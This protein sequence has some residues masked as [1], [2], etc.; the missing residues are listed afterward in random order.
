MC[1]GP[2][3]RC[4]LQYKSSNC[5]GFWGKKDLTEFWKNCCL[6][7]LMWLAHRT[8]LLTATVVWFNREVYQVWTVKRTPLRCLHLKCGAWL[9]CSVW[10]PVNPAAWLLCEQPARVHICQ[11]YAALCKNTEE[12][13]NGIP[14]VFSTRNCCSAVTQQLRVQSVYWSEQQ[15]DAEL[16]FVSVLLTMREVIKTK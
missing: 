16:E 5:G 8:R 2:T 12:V 9:S 15:V 11:E 6:L 10:R 14:S 3:E 4:L 1:P 7:C 13:K